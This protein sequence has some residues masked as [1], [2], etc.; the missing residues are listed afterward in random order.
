MEFKIFTGFSWSW[1]TVKEVGRYGMM[2]LSSHNSIKFY[3]IVWQVI[4]LAQSETWRLDI[5][6]SYWRQLG[7]YNSSGVVD[8]MSTV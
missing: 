4:W 7:I 6:E 5:A 8:K 3:I 1:D 2:K